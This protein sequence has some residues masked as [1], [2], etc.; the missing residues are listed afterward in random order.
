MLVIDNVLGIDISKDKFDVALRRPTGAGRSR[1][2]AN[3]ETGFAQ[4][5]QWLRQLGVDRVHACLEATG[6]YGWALA[7]Y[8]HREGHPV[9]V[10]NPAC[11]KAFADSQLN[12]AKTDRVDAKCLARFCQAL[13]PK[14]WQPPAPE[15]RQLQGLVRRLEGLQGLL[16]QERNRLQAPGL[17]PLVRASLDR[18]SELLAAELK[19]LRQQLTAHL[20]QHPQLRQQRDLLCSIPGLAELTAARVLGELAGLDFTQARQLAA[21]AGLVPSPQQSGTSRQS[22][23]RLSKRGNSRLRRALYWPAI[24]AMRRNP[25]LAAFSQRLL[26]AGKPKLVVIAAVMRKLLHLAFGVLKQQRPFDPAYLPQI[27]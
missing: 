24:V 14:L 8:L 25:V 21:Y 17:C 16:Q 19:Q 27:T 10:V 4:L 7:E 11:A 23:G 13:R 5:R 15:V 2:F 1:A 20:E 18:T 22:R 12:R 6:S 26:A 3:Q 9:S